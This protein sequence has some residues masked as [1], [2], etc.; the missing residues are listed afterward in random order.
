MMEEE[1]CEPDEQNGSFEMIIDDNI[2]DSKGKPCAL[3]S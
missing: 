1:K 2:N 3:K